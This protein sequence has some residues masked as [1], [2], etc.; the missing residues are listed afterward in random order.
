MN[1][2]ERLKKMIEDNHG[3]IT[4]KMLAEQNIHRQYLKKLADEGYIENVARGVYMTPDRHISEYYTVGEQYKSGVFSH[5]TA[6]YFYDMI[7]RTPFELDMTFPS[8][9]RISNFMVKAHYVS[10]DKFELGLTTK[11]MWD[12]TTIRVYNLERTIC[13][14]IRDRNKIDSQIFNTVLKEYMKRKDKKLNLLYEY[15][16]EFRILKILKV[17]LD[18]LG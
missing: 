1:Q 4:T 2:T 6:L 3:I 9:V 17:Y 10:K 12:D 15:A 11:I 5:N 16:K 18:V 8:N 13:D 7:D 14:I